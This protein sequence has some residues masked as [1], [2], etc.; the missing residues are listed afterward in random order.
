MNRAIYTC[1]FCAATSAAHAD[2]VLE[3]GGASAAC[4]GDFSRVAVQGLSLRVDSAPPGQDHSFV[5]DG[6]EK[7]GVA[8]DH[9]RKQFFEMEFDDDAIDFQGDVMKST[10]TMVDRKMQQVQ[11]QASGHMAARCMPSPGHA[12]PPEGGA[13]AGPIGAGMPQID[14]KMMEQLM[15]Q[16]MQGMSPEQRAKMQEAMK[17]L[18]AS[19]YA[20]IGSAAPSEPVIEAT[21]EQ[22]EVNGIACTVERVTADGVLV[23]EDCRASLDAIGIDAADLKRLQRAFARMQKF[24]ASMRDNLHFVNAAAKHDRADP[25]HL[26]VAR[27]CFEQGQPAGDVTLK[28]SRES[29]PEEWFRTP[30]DYART[31]LGLHGR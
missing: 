11:A 30:P 7:A 25:Q 4:H 24:A 12:C 19:G 22:R 3:Y 17:N 18:R 16:N 27:R 20:G 8:L 6:A 23:R 26:L 5:Y 14:P 9:R 13:M 1:I 31:D 28:L 21:G 29:P 10:S 15:Q 2:V